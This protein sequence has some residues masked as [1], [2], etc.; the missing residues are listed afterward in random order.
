MKTIG[1]L[2]FCTGKYVKFLDNYITSCEKFF[3]PDVKKKYFIF[4]DNQ[5]ELPDGIS[6]QYIQQPKLGWPYD[7][8]KRYEIAYDQ[9]HIFEG[10]DYLIMTNA[11]FVYNETVI[12][13]EIFPTEQENWLASIDHPNW[14]DKNNYSEFPYEGRVQSTAYVAPEDRRKYLQACL[15]LGRTQEFLQLAKYVKEQS[16]IDL[17]NGIIGMYWDESYINKYWLSFPPKILPPNYSYPETYNIPGPK[18]IIMLEKG[19]HGG[20]DFLRSQ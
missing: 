5:P 17:A 14:Y 2:L 12:S 10:I 8:L 6:Y 16:A 19:L 9:K 1:I 20:H 7:T 15:V 18:K 3:L 13:E 11:N 4:T